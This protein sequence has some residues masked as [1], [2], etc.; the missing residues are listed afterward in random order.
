MKQLDI[1]DIKILRQL[2]KNASLSIEEISDRIALSRNA[3]WR[4]I[5]RLEDDGIINKRVAI[6]NADALDLGQM[7]IVLISTNSHDPKWLS[8]FRSAIAEMPEIMGAHRMSGDLDYILRV[9]VRDVRAYDKFYQRLISKVP[10]SNVS[11]SFVMEDLKDST[12]LPL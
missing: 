9:R 1:N 10:I 3:C 7:V 11:S 4:R 2:Q 8:L 12:E 5:R 6:V